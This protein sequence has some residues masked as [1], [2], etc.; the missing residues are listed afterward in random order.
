MNIT[1]ILAHPYPK[2]FNHAIAETCRKALKDN[3]H[4]VFFHDLYGEN[5]DPVM[6]AR[7]L[8]GDVSDDSL[9]EMHCREIR[10][11]G[12]ILIIH[13]N[14]WGQPPAMLKGW[15]DRVLRHRV[16]YQFDE[17]D[18]GSGVPEGLLKAGTAIVFNT[19]NT[20][21]DREQEIFGDPLER[22]WR[23]CIFNFCGVKNVRRKTFSA[24]AGS[25]PET[26]KEWLDE[27]RDTISLFF[28]K[29]GEA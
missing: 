4:T 20:F 11:A 24:V 13:P 7:E 22:I 3:G 27:A 6:K 25:T 23:D 8:A 19:S 26:R 9:V 29:S 14:W 12:G 16:A 1:L 2:S 17:G 21:P 10:D 18:N 5:F 28:P 15:V